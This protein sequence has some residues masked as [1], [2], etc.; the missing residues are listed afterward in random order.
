MTTYWL[1]RLYLLLLAMVY[2][3]RLPPSSVPEYAIPLLNE[4]LVYAFFSEPLDFSLL[5]QLSRDVEA[6]QKQAAEFSDALAQFNL[7]LNSS[8]I[9][10]DL[11]GP[12]E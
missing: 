12:V 5:Q 10:C 11:V 7:N 4:D 3:Y 2:I 1:F 8:V 6:L 9:T